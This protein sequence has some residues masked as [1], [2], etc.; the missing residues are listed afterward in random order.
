M[1]G[2]DVVGSSSLR[3]A[4][5]LAKLGTDP[6]TGLNPVQLQ[7]T[8]EQIRAER[9]GGRKE[10]RAFRSPHLFLGPYPMDDRGGGLNGVNRKRLR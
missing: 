1:P 10:K 2:P 6:K 8:P 4:E 5:I 9:V 3:I 7:E